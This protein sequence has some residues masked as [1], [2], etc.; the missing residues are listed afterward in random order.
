MSL[1]K[2]I[3]FLLFMFVLLVV[4]SVNSFDY[5]KSLSEST[6]K[7]ETSTI[8][9][10]FELFIKTVNEIKVEILE[11]FKEK[12][13]EQTPVAL[14][15]TEDVIANDEVKEETEEI[16]QEIKTE[17]LNIQV[18]EE[19]QVEQEIKEENSPEVIEEKQEPE[20]DTKIIQEEINT[21]LKDKKIIFE[22]RS[23]TITKESILAVKDI[24][25][26]LNK[27]DSLMVEVAGHT[28]SRGKASL[29]KKLSQLRANSVRKAL[30]YYGINKDRL[31]AMG[32]GEEFPIAKDDKNG[33]SLI[34]RRIEF[35]IV[36][37][38]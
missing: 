9:N 37:V 18:E 29:N 34:N 26:I 11:K 36:G 5:N 25:K 13:N 20:V 21:I 7:N 3:I 19:I 4:Y 1:G 30:I 22:R 8:S 10:K 23:T 33:L 28:D 14:V 31:T 38:K 12:N 35:N 32:Y 15:Q 6:V 16:T 2:K 24:A 17:T 27:Y